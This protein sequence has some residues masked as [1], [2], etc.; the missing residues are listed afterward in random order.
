MV[1]RESSLAQTPFPA[2]AASLSKKQVIIVLIASGLGWMFDSV[3]INLYTVALPQLQ[4]E[5]GLT[6]QAIGGISSLFLLGYSLGSLAGGTM[7]D[8]LGRRLSLG[9]SIV[10]YTAFAALTGLV[11]SVAT[12]G[13]AR[14]LTGIGGGTELPVGST[15]VAEVAPARWRALCVGLMNSLFSLGIFVAS[16]L[17]TVA[18]GWR[19]AFALTLPIGAVVWLIRLGAE[20]S[21]HYENVRTAISDTGMKRRNITFTELMRPEYRWNTTRQTVLWFGYWMC[22][23]TFVIFFPRYLQMHGV[24][25]NEVA[26]YMGAYGI[27]GMFGLI[28]CGYLADVLGR[29]VSITLFCGIA[30]VSAWAWTLVTGPL[31]TPLIGGVLFTFLVAP[32]SAMLPYTAESF[33]TT[34]RGTGQSVAIGLSR[35]VAV[36]APFAAG[37]IVASVGQTIEFWISSAFLLVTIA[38][39]WSG[40]ESA[41]ADLADGIEEGA[42]VRAAAGASGAQSADRATARSK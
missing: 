10:C 18:G 30:V 36:G 42:L 2:R 29:R 17:V 25:G 34:V 11:G 24:A 39:A 35:L 28:L 9:I 41:G 23:W 6:V 26:W 5:F 40:R 21:P 19:W 20:E 3:V 1:T 27:A 37:W 4:K 14:F 15:Y 12:L 38:A 13:G 31:L 33:P 8:Y 7:A 22:W 32:G 16:V